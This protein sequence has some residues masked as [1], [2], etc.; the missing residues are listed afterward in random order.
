MLLG[1]SL[2]RHRSFAL[3]PYQIPDLNVGK[4]GEVPASNIYQLEFV[5]GHIYYAYP[6]GSS[7]LSVPY[8]VIMNALG[9]SSANSDGTYNASNEMKIETSLAALLMAAFAAIVF[10]TA[11]LLLPVYWSVVI[12][13]GTAFG[14]QV[15]STAS[16]A[17][18]SDTWGIL[19]MGLVVWLLLKA[20]GDRHSLR[21]VLLA[22]LLS[23]AYFVR[24]TYCL[25][26]L[27]ISAYVAFFHSAVLVRYVA[28]G[29]VWLTGFIAYSWYHFGKVLPTY[30]S[31]NK[32]TFESF[33]SA[34]AGHL[35]SPSRGLLVFSPVI[36]FVVYLLIRYARSLPSIRLAV[37]APSIIAAH[38]FVVSAVP[39]WW[40]G[41]SYGSRLTAG[42]VPWFALLGI[43]GIA[44]RHAWLP[45]QGSN[46]PRFI[47]AGELAIGGVLLVLSIALNGLGATAQRTW[48]WNVKPVNVDQHPERVWDWK[49][50]QFLADD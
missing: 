14:S 29:V 36:L 26:I 46:A 3:D 23:W 40:G 27:A 8:I 41:H 21:P 7:I 1:E 22:T 48:W 32:L 2:L 50:P 25:P 45:Q 6:P 33:W 10:F 49:H 18:W 17:M 43:L 31:L 11:R 44:A 39:M 47:Q 24:P 20:Q 42:L 5:N 19:L 28:T 15:W 37:L 9:F 30:Y 38:L 34:L 35:I 16:R 12:A 13:A 4:P